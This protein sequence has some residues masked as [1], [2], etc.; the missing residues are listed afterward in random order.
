M[1]SD[2]SSFPSLPCTSLPGIDLIHR[3]L[4]S[5]PDLTSLPNSL[6]TLAVAL[7]EQAKLEKE[8]KLELV[9]GLLSSGNCIPSKVTTH[10][11]YSEQWLEKIKMLIIPPTR[12][13]EVSVHHSDHDSAIRIF[14]HLP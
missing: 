5:F 1:F 6:I 13:D 4:T 9:V 2:T 3:T 10:T 8:L 7:S 14:I 11:G 12:L